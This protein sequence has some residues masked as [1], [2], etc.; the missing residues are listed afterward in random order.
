MW[1]FAGR[2]D[3][4]A[5]HLFGNLLTAMLSTAWAEIDRSALRHNIQCVRELSPDSRIVAMIK[6]NAYGHGLI[7]VARTLAPVSDKLG[8]AR[9]DEAYQLRSAGIISPLLLM[10]TQLSD[11]QLRWCAEQGV[12]VTVHSPEQAGQIVRQ[13]IN[14]SLEIWLKLDTGMNR[15]GLTPDALHRAHSI[16]AQSPH[17]GPL[18]LMSHF[19]CADDLS[20]Q[21]TND[22]IA[23]FEKVA[24]D[25]PPMDYSLANSAGLIAWP[26]SR[27]Q[28]LRPG[29]MLY[30]DDPTG[31]QTLDLKPVMRL[32]SRVV[33][34]KNLLEGDSVG[35]N[36]RWI[37]PRA[38]RIAAVGVGYGDGYPRQLPNQTPVLVNGQKFPLVGRISMDICSIDIS[39]AKQ[40]ISV[41]D[42]V[43][44][45]GDG[46][47]A[48]DIAAMA[49]T[50]SY[51]L[52]TGVTQRVQRVYSET[53]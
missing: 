15:L 29:I 17:V 14:K 31:Q 51:H 23:Y 9:F 26:E 22:Q 43:T 46:L 33:A 47:P 3:L 24:G 49:G 40:P 18:R 32:K 7:E 8:I 19:S 25:L 2:T 20:S 38:S 37:A 44:L 35:Y 10:G 52:Y 53:T 13:P 42:E 50:I 36:A 12:A 5:R 4:R 1:S 27:Q 41:G 11:D 34:I 16:L 6:A 30:G 21:T 45:W 48:T 39:E 28:W